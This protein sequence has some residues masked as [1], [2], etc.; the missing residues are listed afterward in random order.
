[1]FE[2]H[3]FLIF[4]FTEADIHNKFSHYLNTNLHF[5]YFF[6]LKSQECSDICEG[7]SA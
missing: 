6:N 1:M 7:Q 4:P 3:G 2:W 5:M